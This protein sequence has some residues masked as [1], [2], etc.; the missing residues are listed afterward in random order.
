AGQHHQVGVGQVARGG[1]EDDVEAGLQAEGV[2]VG[3]VADPRQP[4]DRRPH[5]GAVRA[6]PAV[7]VEGVLGVEPEAGMPRQ[8]AVDG[9]PGQGLQPV[10][11]GPSPGEVAAELV[12]D[13][14]RDQRLVGGFQQRHG[15]VQGGEQAAAVDVADH[16]DGKVRVPGEPHVHVVA[17]TQVDLG[18]TARPLRHDH[19]EPGGQVVV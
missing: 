2:D 18:G 17:G 6:A 12:D 15:A 3:E 4:D 5:A 13:E 8:H 16:D 7:E 19:V 14:P 1:G 9:P 10:E 11:A